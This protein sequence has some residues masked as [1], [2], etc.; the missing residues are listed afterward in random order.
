ML[1][2]A[3]R[4]IQAKGDEF[5]TQELVAEAGVALQT[6][7]RYFASKDELILAVIGDAM[8]DACEQWTATA[9]EMPDPLDR[10]RFYLTSTLERLA[11]WSRRGDGPV[12][13][14][15]ALAS[16]SSVPQG[17]GR[18]G[19]AVR[20]PTARRSARRRRRGI[21]ESADPEWDS[22]LLAELVRAVYHYYAFAAPRDGEI[23]SGQGKAVAVLPDGL[24]WAPSNPELQEI[25]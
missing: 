1:D 13:R 19:E 10:L 25:S 16:A 22:W 2:A 18:S 7:Y 14:V 24:G 3:R 20:R 12:R 8:N 4:L 11:W 15:G 21:A 5:T 23:G 17:T 9:S 6:F